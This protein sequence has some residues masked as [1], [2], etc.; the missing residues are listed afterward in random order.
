MY[1]LDTTSSSRLVGR[2]RRQP[3]W[4]SYSW[5]GTLTPRRPGTQHAVAAGGGCGR[6][7]RFAERIAHREEGEPCHP[8]VGAQELAHAVLAPHHRR[9]EP[10]A[11][12]GGGGQRLGQDGGVPVRGGGRVRRR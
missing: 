6:R 10:G 11:G 1:P 12:G 2:A 9:G 3:W 5:D 7:P 4:S 8:T